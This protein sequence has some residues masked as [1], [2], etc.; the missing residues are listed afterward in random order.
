MRIAARRPARAARSRS[1]APDQ[2]EIAGLGEIADVD[3]DAP[4]DFDL[5]PFERGSYPVRLIDARAARRLDRRQRLSERSRRVRRAGGESST[6]SP[7]ESTA[8]STP[9]ARWRAERRSVRT[10]PLE[11]LRRPRVRDR[12]AAACPSGS[13]SRSA[14][15][16]SPPPPRRGG[17][18]DARARPRSP[19]RAIGSS[20]ASS[21]PRERRHACEQVGVAGEVDAAI[22]ARRAGSRRRRRRAPELVAAAVVNGP[23]G[24][25]LDRPDPARA[26]RARSS[27]TLAKAAAADQLPRPRPGRRSAPRYR[28]G[29]ARR[30]RGG[31]DAGVRSRPRRSPRATSGAG[32]GPWRRMIPSSRGAQDRVGEQPHAAD[33][34]QGGRVSDV[35]DPVVAHLAV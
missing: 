5:L 2:V 33:L 27:T 11:Q 9:G 29:A 10:G 4:A 12:A 3:R 22:G 18:R 24:G 30:S 1:K 17:G 15:A 13:G 21:S 25:D 28:P 34:D 14:V 19:S 32:S 35:G 26:R 8:A 6:D 20:A 31:R 23:R 16:A 7:G